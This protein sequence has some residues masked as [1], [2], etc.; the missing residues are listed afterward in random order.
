MKIS[1]GDGFRDKEYH[2]FVSGKPCIVCGRPG[3]AHHYG[4][5]AE[6]R[7][8]THKASDQFLVPL[9]DFEGSHHREVEKLGREKFE[10]KYGVNFDVHSEM[11]HK[12]YDEREKSDGRYRHQFSLN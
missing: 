1:K 7:G 5:Q 11:L 12:L 6:G 9:C 2:K 10:I 3:Q 8:M 4:G